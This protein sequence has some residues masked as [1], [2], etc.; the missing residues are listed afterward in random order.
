VTEPRDTRRLVAVARLMVGSVMMF[1]LCMTRSHRNRHAGGTVIVDRVP[2]AID[3]CKR[4]PASGEWSIGADVRASGDNVLRIVREAGT[5]RLWAYV[6][7]GGMVPI[8]AADCSE[9]NVDFST[10][11]PDRTTPVGGHASVTCV[12]G[13][14]RVDSETFF[15][16][17]AP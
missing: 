8:N 1:A 4:V 10:D 6:K 16:H 7:G 12:S 9:W 14:H 17:C 13:G 2:F 3:G 5:V 11:P 15:D